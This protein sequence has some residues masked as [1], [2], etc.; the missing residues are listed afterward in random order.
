MLAPETGSTKPMAR[1]YFISAASQGRIIAD[2]AAL[3]G[4]LLLI[5]P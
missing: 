1:A 5:R 2:P 4:L 3:R